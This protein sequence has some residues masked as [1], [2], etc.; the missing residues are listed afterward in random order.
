MRTWGPI[1]LAGV[2]AWAQLAMA[3]QLNSLDAR[4]GRIE[5]VLMAVAHR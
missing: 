4:I 2:I 5:S 1:I 3:F